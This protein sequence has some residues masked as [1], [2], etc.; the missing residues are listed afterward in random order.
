MTVVPQGNKRVRTQSKV[1]QRPEATLSNRELL[2]WTCISAGHAKG[3][4]YSE[5]T[6]RMMSRVLP[7]LH[8]S[9]ANKEK[10]E[11]QARIISSY[12]YTLQTGVSNAS[13]PEKIIGRKNLFLQ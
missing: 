10:G 6:L 1:G 8:L 2:T 3:R 5:S 12:H 13:N 4:L 11:K 9:L 7:L